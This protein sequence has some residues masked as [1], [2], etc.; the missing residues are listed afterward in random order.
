MTENES[1]SPPQNLKITT[2]DTIAALSPED[3]Q[4]V[5]DYISADDYVALEKLII[6]GRAFLLPKGLEI[7][8][9]AD[10][11]KTNSAI[12]LRIK[13]STAEVWGSV[14]AVT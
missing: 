4:R 2:K 6:S 12:K 13:G 14:T 1:K 8:V 5:F 7:Y 3:M 9:L 10:E 11:S